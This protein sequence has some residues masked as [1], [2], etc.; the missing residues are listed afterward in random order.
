MNM[1]GYETF[2]ASLLFENLHFVVPGN[3][4]LGGFAPLNFRDKE[5]H[6]FLD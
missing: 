2:A 3:T 4:S 5:I 6:S 1:M